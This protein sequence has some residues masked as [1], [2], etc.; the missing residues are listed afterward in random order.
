MMLAAI[1]LAT[2]LLILFLE[3]RQ[4]RQK[5]GL[6]KRRA[7]RHLG[8]YSHVSVHS[9]SSKVARH[10]SQW[11]AKHVQ[12]IP[13]ISSI[14]MSYL[15][16][17]GF[18]LWWVSVLVVPVVY[19]GVALIQSHKLKQLKIEAIEAHLPEAVDVFAR[20]IAAG[21]PME[22]SIRSVANAF[23]GHLGDEFNKLHDAI[24]LG[25]PFQQALSDS[26]ARVDSESYRYF[27][28]ILSLNAETGGPLVEVLTN[29]S[30]SLREKHKLNKKVLALTAEPRTAA[31]V[32][33]GIP[34]VLLTMQF[35]KQ[36]EQL[37]FLLQNEAGQQILLYAVVSIISG[38]LIIKR[39]TKVG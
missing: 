4:N 3:Q 6:V 29:L 18:H 12:L 9:S 34:I 38:L 1:V 36:P 8:V 14:G 33:T 7:E 15:C 27:T 5:Q 32:V 21:V 2:I 11:V 31:R 17:N 39:L 20:A 22:R 23:D 19:R 16:W 28:A 30:H 26:S 37:E 13:A 35:F 24:V 10:L 25:V